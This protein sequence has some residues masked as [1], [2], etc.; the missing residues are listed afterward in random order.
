MQR[1]DLICKLCAPAIVGVFLQHTGPFITTL[2][3]AGWNIVSFILEVVL[4]TTVYK[5]VP[6]LANKK[7]RIKDKIVH[8]RDV[9]MIVHV[10]WSCNSHMTLT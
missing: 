8:T 9:S 10:W 2:I 6:T 7:L 4:I 5:A 1:I 3:I